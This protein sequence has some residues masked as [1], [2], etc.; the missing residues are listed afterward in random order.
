MSGV[1]PHMFS[2]PHTP[3]VVCTMLAISL[4]G[5]LLPLFGQDDT[6]LSDSRVSGRVDVRT[7]RGLGYG[8]SPEEAVPDKQ[9]LAVG[10]AVSAAYDDNITLASVAPEKDFV[11]R[12]APSFAYMQGNADSKD[13]GYLKV[14]YQPTAVV[15]ADHG[16]ENR[17]DQDVLWDARFRGRVVSLAYGGHVQHLGDP[18]PDTGKP[19]ERWVADQVIRAAWTLREKLSVA[20]AGGQSS[21]FYQDR[22]LADSRETYGE[23][24]LRYEY[25]PKTRIGLAYRAGQ[26]EVD[27]AGDQIVQRGT[28]RMEWKP[29]EKIAVDLEAGAE[30]RTF[31][32]GSS[33]KP[34]VEAKVAWTPAAGTQFSLGGY[35]RT[36]VSAYFAGQ[37]YDVSGV[38][39]GVS[40][41]LGKRWTALMEGGL[42]NASYWRFSGTGTA[43]RRDRI[44][45]LRPSV[46]Y[47]INDDCQLEWFYR[48]E[49]D[50]SNQA[51]F[52]Y[53]DHTVGVRLG[54]QF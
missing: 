21:T 8:K 12:A 6:G 41:R 30:H 11:F 43:D 14:A 18:T 29:R 40:Q 27:G 52:G 34:V 22:G 49:C 50:N 20:A 48:Y 2:E 36:E 35:H 45:F 53:G 13:G 39:A 15:Y 23:A 44:V 51:G 17:V 25:S 26:V 54:Y 47:Q 24:A 9:G 19:T 16:N 7:M 5:I 1:P 32:L 4:A 3:R 31:A 10:V 46:R 28:A 38:S 42:E 37:N 33:T